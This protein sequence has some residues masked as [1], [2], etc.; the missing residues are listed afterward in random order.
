MKLS[1]GVLLSIFVAIHG[2]SVG[3]GETYL[4]ADPQS[5]K[6]IVPASLFENAWDYHRRLESLQQQINSKLTQVRTAISSVLKTSS[7]KT[8][9]QIE[10]NAYRILEL[11][12]PVRDLIF[13]DTKPSICNKNL[14]VLIDSITEFTGF[15]SSNAVTSYDKS[16]QGALQVAYEILQHY[17]GSSVDV[18]Q[19]VVR[20]FIGKNAFL[21]PEEIEELFKSVYNQRLNEWN[22]SSPHIEEFVND[23][24]GKIDG[25]NKNLYRDFGLIQEQVSPAYDALKEEIATCEEFDRTVDPFAIFRNA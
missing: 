1:V 15:G 13:V 7:W 6:V 18:Q 2:A 24:E 11:D 8:L 23:L 10:T 12:S 3:S 17:E 14:R 9:Q 21:E 5:D 19:I 25:F 22:E 16:V 20:S 4:D